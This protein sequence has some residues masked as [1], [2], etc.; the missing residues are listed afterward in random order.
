MEETILPRPMLHSRMPSHVTLENWK[1][2]FR[3]CETKRTTRIARSRRTNPTEKQA[4]LVETIVRRRCGTKIETRTTYQ[5]LLLARCYCMLDDMNLGV[6]TTTRMHH[7]LCA[8]Q[9]TLIS[10]V[11]LQ[12][13]K[14]KR[15]RLRCSESAHVAS[16]SIG[17]DPDVRTVCMAD[18]TKKEQTHWNQQPKIYTASF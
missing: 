13:V 18:G 7:F 12:Q 10:L 16:P 3:L 5:V 9:V 8:R 4:A 11:V 15:E 1:E 14:S 17:S 6:A 2:N